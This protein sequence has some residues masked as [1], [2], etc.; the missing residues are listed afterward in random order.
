MSRSTT[1]YR[2]VIL[3]DIFDLTRLRRISKIM[4]SYGSRVQRSVFEVQGT[5]R[6]IE[7][8]RES[9]DAVLEDP[10]S[11]VYIPLCEPD[12]EKVRRYGKMLFDGGADIEDSG[13][14]LFL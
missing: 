4:E 1:V 11:M 10:D 3:Y 14:A 8:I 6:L 7:T 13:P 2:W 12:W 5:T 9:V